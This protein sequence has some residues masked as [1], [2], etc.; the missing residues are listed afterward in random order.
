MAESRSSNGLGIVSLVF[1]ILG[2]LVCWVPIV[3]LLAFP[4]SVLG[5]LLGGIGLL[6]GI[7]GRKWE[8]GTSIAGIILSFLA[9]FVCMSMAVATGAALEE[10]SRHLEETSRH[11][12][13][14]NA[15]L[16]ETEWKIK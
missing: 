16:E 9:L 5:L 13:G 6:I 8:V 14:I 10:T 3:G 2:L 15:E 12:E 4:A 1:G 11:L 7:A